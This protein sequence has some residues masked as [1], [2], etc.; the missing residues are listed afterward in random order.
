MKKKLSKKNSSTSLDRLAGHYHQQ[1]S[2]YTQQ[3]STAPFPTTTTTATAASS[4][5]S[6]RL[7]YSVNAPQKTKPELE[8]VA[9]SA[10]LRVKSAPK[11]TRVPPPKYRPHPPLMTQKRLVNASTT[12]TGSSTTL[13]QQPTSTS[14]GLTGNTYGKSISAENIL[15][16]AGDS[17]SSRLPTPRGF[18]PTPGKNSEQGRKLGQDS[19]TMSSSSLVKTQ[20]N[21]R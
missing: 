8:E 3:P 6:Q 14:S 20:E 15:N 17:T 9:T 2:S 7:S 11:F 5:H 12:T 13:D 16:F 21:I 18:F 4:Q 1:S 10:G 19:K